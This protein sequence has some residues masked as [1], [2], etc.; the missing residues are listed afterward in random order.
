VFGASR[1]V[2]VCV[3]CVFCVFCGSSFAQEPQPEQ[4]KFETGAE[5]VLVDVSVVSNDGE[6]VTGLTASDFKLI[7]NGQ[8]RAIH[9]VQFISSRG[10]KAPVEAPRLTDSSSNDDPST[11]RLLL[12]VIDENYLRIGGARAVLRTAE[13]VMETLAPG[14]LVGLARLPTGRGG[15]EFTTN[16]D[17]I[18]RALS[19][20]MG[21]QPRPTDRV[22]LGRRTPS[23]PTT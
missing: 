10:M 17:R 20:I 4:P 3:F 6:P 2:C 7:V 18:R 22:R 21:A 19:N 11:G 15:V 13:R 14:D 12:F 8:P 9:T 1:V 23:T 16:R 5:V